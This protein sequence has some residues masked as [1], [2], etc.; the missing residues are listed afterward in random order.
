MTRAD[1]STL[2]E[3]SW[4]DIVVDGRGN[5]YV[6][7]TSFDFLGGEFAPESSRWSPPMVRLSR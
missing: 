5:A 3:R 7:N 4:N 6:G 1:L 2:S